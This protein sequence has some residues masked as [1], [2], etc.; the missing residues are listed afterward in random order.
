MKTKIMIVILLSSAL[1]QL[2]LHSSEEL[3]GISFFSPRSQDMNAARDT[4]GWHPF[5][6]RYDM[7][8][9]Y[10]VFSITPEYNQSVRPKNISLALFN[11]DTFSLSGS[12]IPGRADTQELLADYFG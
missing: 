11:S 6:H 4:V 3:R 1:L 12:Q 7:Q 10:F 5:I 9:N 2:H 8:Q